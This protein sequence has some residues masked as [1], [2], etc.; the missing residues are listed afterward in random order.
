LG[1]LFPD[2]ELTPPNDTNWSLGVTMSL[3]LFTSGERPAV[4]RQDRDALAGLRFQREAL[5][6]RLEQRI[7]SALHEAGASYAS[8]QLARDAAEASRR[9]LELVTDAYSRGAVSIIELLDAQNASVLS[10]ESAANAVYDFLIDM[11]EVERSLGKFY[12][13]ASPMEVEALFERV[14]DFFE[15]RGRRP[16]SR[17]R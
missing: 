5:A 15:E 9:S 16:P 10:E 8:I 17:S 14:D 13:R 2:L 7:R 12:F 11:L 1:S 6:E 3:P 4:R